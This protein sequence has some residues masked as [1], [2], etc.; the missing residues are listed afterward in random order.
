MTDWDW[1]IIT[2]GYVS[3]AVAVVIGCAALRTRTTRDRPSR[4]DPPRRPGNA[5]TW[6]LV[7]IAA[8]FGASLVEI[9]NRHPADI[10]KEDVA[11]FTLIAANDVDEGIR[12]RLA[13]KDFAAGDVIRKADTAVLPAACQLPLAR[14]AVE[15]GA[16][17]VFGGELEDGSSVAVLSAQR[18]TD[19]AIVLSKVAIFEE[20]LDQGAHSARRYV[21]TLVV[22]VAE[23]EWLALSER[24]RL[25]PLQD[26][27]ADVDETS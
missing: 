18:R 21:V 15:V 22:K 25:L 19:C 11:A 7:L 24:V 9:R 4:L 5:A 14:V 3:L 13:L 10:T 20:E 2:V 26:Q 23:A 1:G 6:W 16:R 12:G 17:D 27:A 8:V